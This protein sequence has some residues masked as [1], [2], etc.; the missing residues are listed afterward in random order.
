MR[1]AQEV[2][3]NAWQDASRATRS[4]AIGGSCDTLFCAGGRGTNPL[5]VFE[6]PKYLPGLRGVVAQR[7]RFL[8]SV[9]RVHELQLG[10]AF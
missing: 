10:A 9:P 8:F 4:A 7:G 6:R 1:A 3:S 5:H 2:I